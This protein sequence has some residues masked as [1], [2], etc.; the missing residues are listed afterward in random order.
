MDGE[1]MSSD[2]TQDRGTSGNLKTFKPGQSGNPGGQPKWV[3][4]VRDAL[5]TC[6]EKGAEK[7]EYIIENG[8]HKDVIAATK[9]AAEFTLRKPKQTHRVEHKGQDPLAGLTPEEIVK[10]V[11]GEKP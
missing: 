7:L 5:R 6:V 4:Q 1:T 9:L 10:F 2:S 11:K 3:K 8:E